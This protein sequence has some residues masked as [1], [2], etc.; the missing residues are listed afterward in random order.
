[1]LRKIRIW[2]I[3]QYIGHLNEFYKDGFLVE[4]Y[5]GETKWLVPYVSHVKSDWPEGQQL[6]NC[7]KGPGKSKR[8]C[9]ACGVLT[10]DIPKTSLGL[11]D[12]CD[13]RKQTEADVLLRYHQQRV[14]NK[15]SGAVGDQEKICRMISLHPEPNAF[16]DMEL[17]YNHYGSYALMPFDIMHTVPHGLVVILKDILLAYT[18]T[19][20]NL[21]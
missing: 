9:R 20:F 11:G 17:W 12:R 3:Q 6:C 1:M 14:K 8:N 10:V 5:T 21:T 4:L 13:P 16:A 18:G 15:V 7:F 2:I 19:N